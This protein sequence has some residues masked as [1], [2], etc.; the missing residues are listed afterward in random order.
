L[1]LLRLKIFRIK[2]R[3][4]CRNLSAWLFPRAFS[5]L[6]LLA[7]ALFAHPLFAHPL[8]AQSPVTGEALVRGSLNS[9][10]ARH[11]LTLA[12]WDPSKPLVILLEYSPQERWELDDNSGFFVFDQIGY[13]H[14]RGGEL[15]GALSVAAGSQLP[16]EG[17]RLQAT[18]G[19]P[20]PGTFYVVVYNNST[21]PMGYT[22][23]ATNGGFSDG[24]GQVIAGS[25]PG[26]AGGGNSDANSDANSDVYPL[27][28]VP[29]P[30]PTPR[31]TPTP[32]PPLRASV[33]RGLL[34]K[35]YAQDFF[36]LEVVDTGLPLAIEMVYDPA[37]QILLLDTFNFW[38]FDEEQFRTQKISGARPEL[39]PNRAAGKLIYRD[40]VPVWVAT[41]EQPLDRY[42][43]VVNQHRHALSV[44]YR[45]TVQNGV[46]VD[47]GQ[48]AQ[49]VFT[50][51]R[52]LSGQGSTL[53]IVRTGDTLGTIAQAVYGNR[54]YYAAICGVNGLFNCN[55]LYSGQRLILPPATTLSPI[56]PSSRP[57]VQ[58]TRPPTADAP[59]A[60][61]PVANN[62]LD[63]AAGESTLQAF[64][65][66]LKQTPLAETLT[67]PGPFTLFAF[68]ND[69]FDALPI[70]TQ[71]ELLIDP[72]RAY[73]LLSKYVVS[74]RLSPEWVTRA[75]NVATLTSGLLRLE[76]DDA[77][78]FAVNGVPVIAGPIEAANGVIYVV[79]EVLE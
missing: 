45:L 72:D 14:F 76:P 69:A 61:A 63:V 77:N 42:R 62:L 41:I 25:A 47:E 51:P 43:L 1:E 49:A 5:L 78:G 21:V 67:R 19:A 38:I 55:R 27:V 48:Q 10:Y 68:S 50:E 54:G 75:K 39:E 46:L 60:G 52:T 40:D 35:R 56:I 34:D 15:P 11:I 65:D 13:D 73:A 33:V 24:G 32:I 58:S 18:I 29:G 57:L 64:R 53:W 37:E 3:L 26:P 12:A 44:G 23:R 70:E 31:P 28:V 4:T 59:P 6:L 74:G 20:V 17:R 22:L 2:H 79:G 16:G 36:T 8:H 30:T 9:P 66:L 7:I 71:D